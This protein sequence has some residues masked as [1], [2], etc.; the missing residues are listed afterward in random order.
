MHGSI[1]MEELGWCKAYK[2]KFIFHILICA[3]AKADKREYPD[4]APAKADRW[5]LRCMLA[6]MRVSASFYR[7]LRCC[8]WM[9]R[10]KICIKDM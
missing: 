4:F 7:F 5:E 10:N 3:P 6:M 8:K 1:I 9:E 2:V